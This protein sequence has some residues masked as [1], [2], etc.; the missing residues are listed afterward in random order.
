MHMSLRRRGRIAPR[1]RFLMRE[2][3]RGV[4]AEECKTLQLAEPGT[5]CKPG[6]MSGLQGCLA[7]RYYL[8]I[9]KTYGGQ[10]AGCGEPSIFLQNANTPP[11]YRMRPA[12]DLTGVLE[13]EDS[14]RQRGDG[15]LLNSIMSCAKLGKN[16]EHP[17]SAGIRSW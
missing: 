6:V 7:F 16:S 3:S 1:S 4:E 10:H 11:I 15:L 5:P 8:N 9:A 2:L 13:I 14:N 12:G 17:R